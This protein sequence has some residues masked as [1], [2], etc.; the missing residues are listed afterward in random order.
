LFKTD[1]ASMRMK[2]ID[3]QS[4]DAQQLSFHSPQ[5]RLRV[6]RERFAFNLQVP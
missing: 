2:L 4:I 5:S 3:L 1:V 6:G